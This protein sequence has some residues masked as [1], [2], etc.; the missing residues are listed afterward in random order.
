MGTR[1]TSFWF[2]QMRRLTDLTAVRIF[3]A[4]NK[5]IVNAMKLTIIFLLFALLKV[6]A[7]GFSQTLSLS[8]KGLTLQKVFS[9][10]EAQTGYVVFYKKELLKKAK[11]VTLSAKNMLLP[12]FLEKVMKEQPLDYEISNE[13]ILISAK[14]R[15]ISKNHRLEVT[16]AYIPPKITGTIKTADGQ[17]VEGATIVNR[18]SNESVTSDKTGSFSINADK[19]DVLQISFVGFETQDIKVGERTSITVIMKEKISSLN[20][21]VVTGYSTQEKRSITGAMSSIK[22]EALE[23]YPVQS[24]DR[25]IQGQVSGVNV[26]GANGVPGGPVQIQIRGTGS[27]TAGTQ[28]L[29]IVDGIQ[30]NGSTTSTQTASNPLAFL[31]TNDI[32]SIEILKDGAAASIYGAQAANGVVLVTTKKGVAGKTKFNIS[33]YN[34]ITRPMPEVQMLNSQ[35]FL[36]ARFE[37]RNNRYTTRTPE[38][39]RADVL[40]GVGLP[41]NL[42][43]KDIADLKTYNWQEAA[44]TTGRTDNIDVSVSGGNN[45]TNFFLSSSYNKTDGNV[46]GIDFERA[47]VKL[48][49]GHKANDRLSFSTNINLSYIVQNG[50][51]GSSGSSGAFAAPQ[52]SAP[53]I[54]PFLRIYNEDGTHNAPIEGFPGSSNR[55]P[56]YETIVHILQSRTK[57]AVA[58]FQ[59]S[60][61]ITDDLTFK[62]FYGIDFRVINDN[63]YIDP[64]TRS[65]AASRGE[66]SVAEGQ[67]SN[68]LTNQTLNFKK[69]FNGMHHLSVLGG[70]EYRRDVRNS[71]S[72]FGT[73][74][75]TYQFRTLQSAAIIESG[76]GSWTGFKRFGFLS[77]ANYD[78]DK[79]YMVSAVLRY[80]GS[81]RFG[82]NNQFGY[83]PAISAGWDMAEENFLKSTT[84][85]NQL[86]IRVGY[87]ET[88]N[89]DIGNFDSRGL[90]GSSSAANYNQEPGIRPTGI[91]NTDLKWERNV[92]TNIG[93]DYTFFDERISGSVDVFRR[94][95][96]DLLLDRPIP[97]LSGFA[98]LTSNVGELKNEGLE[99]EIR[100][101]NVKT[102][103]FTWS[104][105][106]NISFLKN[107]VVKLADDDSVL[108]GNQ[109]VRVGYSMGTNFMAQYAGV[110]SAT[111]RPMWYDAKGEITYNPVNPT[112]YAIFGDQLSDYFGGFTNN[113][114]YKGLSLNV[115]FHYDFGRDLSNAGMNS[116]WY[117][118]GME[119]RNSLE[120]IYLARWT[121]PGQ[122]TTVPRTYDG[123]AETNGAS[124]TTT[125]SRF[126][127]D[128]SFIRLKQVVFG[129]DLPG[130]V[131]KK[132]RLNSVRLYAQA[133]NLF[134]WTK[135][136]GY[137][138]ELI[139]NSGEFTS[140]QGTVPQTRAYTF[141]IQVGL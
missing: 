97:Y 28:P 96:K 108:P 26:M 11:P 10:I 21:I 70:V 41:D 82:K 18:N 42:T 110:N 130:N 15:V 62:S 120:R 74:F 87:G 140:T 8:G 98:S 45:T 113:F 129:Y 126:L 105:N 135:W 61:K 71:S 4:N 128:A 85:I 137:D 141:G 119:A 78:F 66:L 86:K 68:F 109:S 58:N 2:A 57:A 77:Q 55:N 131:V 12:E 111:G 89:D 44:F 37:A 7:T 51:S 80:D 54:L 65:G 1:N 3:A 40:T 92:T 32:E 104:T 81:S 5:T 13:T 16:E 132:M 112:D 34:G 125:S 50:T 33:Y 56:I 116:R 39:N 88:G 14:P 67:N 69:T 35:Q 84:W 123:G 76:T 49:L 117:N 94:V 118:N 38:K 43:D 53:M 20:E 22:K 122:L 107:R 100:T 138:P 52:Y 47:T 95:S 6:G 29:Y 139:I 101:I 46:I 30:L 133:V 121:K 83:F 36:A 48:N 136:T 60:Y 102:K 90:F 127:E 25:A 9:E 72:I 19:G 103:N 73:G 59:A 91:A 106:F 23:N 115:L 63:R 99:V 134:T 24:F 75:T 93:V 124:H 27:I 17:P 114:K 64:R 31:N 79:K